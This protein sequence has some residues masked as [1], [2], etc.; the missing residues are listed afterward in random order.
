[1]PAGPRRHLLGQQI[2]LR[3]SVE[4]RGGEVV[5]TL[6]HVGP[7][8]GPAWLR[9][10]AAAADRAR[11]HCT[12][13]L[14]ATTDRF[15][16]SPWFHSDDSELC[17]AQARAIDLRD[18]VGYVALM[19]LLDPDASPGDCRSLLTRWGQEAKGRS[20]GRPRSGHR[21]GRPPNTDARKARLMPL[22][23][24]LHSL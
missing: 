6:N 10:M 18:A 22:V 17:L 5:A 9:D 20:G 13:L 8:R 11:R 1:V 2:G 15:I 23:L 12:I 19:T 24:A 16:R 21:P 3:A 4:A 14:A 7:G